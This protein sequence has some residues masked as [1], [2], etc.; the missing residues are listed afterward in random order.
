MA[1]TRGDRSMSSSAAKLRDRPQPAS[2]TAGQVEDWP[3][4]SAW[5]YRPTVLLVV[6]DLARRTRWKPPASAPSCDMP[7]RPQSQPTWPFSGGSQVSG[8]L[9]KGPKGVPPCGDERGRPGWQIQVST[10]SS[11]QLRA[12]TGGWRSPYRLFPAELSARCGRADC[13]VLRSA[14]FPMDVPVRDIACRYQVAQQ[15]P[16]L[17]SADRFIKELDD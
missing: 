4:M 14:L 13:A 2:R 15:A 3:V 10:P 16:H 9:S 1:V 12:A 11:P 5:A 8:L 17:S 6:R 7:G